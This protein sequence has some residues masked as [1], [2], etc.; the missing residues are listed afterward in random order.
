MGNVNGWQ[1]EDE[2]KYAAGEDLFLLIN[3]GAEVYHEYGFQEALFQTYSTKEGKSI[4][5][6]VYEM[7]SQ[8]AA[9]GIYSFKTGDDGHPIDL[10]HEG[11]L[12]ENP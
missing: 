8:E 11:W 5:L 1:P 2:A 9:F 7:V 10:G 12:E 6:E 3:G 4:N